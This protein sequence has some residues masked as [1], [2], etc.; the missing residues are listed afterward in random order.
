MRQVTRSILRVLACAS[1]HIVPRKIAFPPQGSLNGG[2]VCPRPSVSTRVKVT[3]NG[4]I[5]RSMYHVCS[6]PNRFESRAQV[7]LPL[8]SAAS[9]LADCQGDEH[10]DRAP[11]R[12]GDRRSMCR[13][14]PMRALAAVGGDPAV[15]WPRRHRPCSLAGRFPGCL[16]RPPTARTSAAGVPRAVGCLGH[17]LEVLC[18]VGQI[19]RPSVEHVR[20][21][22]PCCSTDGRFVCV[23]SGPRM[24]RAVARHAPGG[25]HGRAEVWRWCVPRR[26]AS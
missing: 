1:F 8:S 21:L 12:P 24:G 14:C 23:W 26:S 19:S 10:R 18:A 7:I 2:W 5:A 3:I 16:A 25:S 15:P 6:P 11:F 22:L 17:I 13:T 4:R 9:S 20:P